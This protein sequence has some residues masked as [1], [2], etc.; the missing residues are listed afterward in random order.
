MFLGKHIKKNL[1]Y[2]IIF[3]LEFSCVEGYFKCSNKTSTLIYRRRNS[4]QNT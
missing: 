1:H 4:T 2:I 3:K